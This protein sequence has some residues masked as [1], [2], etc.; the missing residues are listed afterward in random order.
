VLK[1]RRKSIRLADK[2]YKFGSATKITAAARQNF[3][4]A[5]HGGGAGVRVY[6]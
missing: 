4:A 5:A 6:S 3:G 1:L 2:F